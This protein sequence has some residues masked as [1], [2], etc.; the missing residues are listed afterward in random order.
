MHAL[1]LTC[2]FDTAKLSVQALLL[3]LKNCDTAHGS[4]SYMTL[5]KLARA[6]LLINR[7]SGLEP[8]KTYGHIL[9]LSLYIYLYV[10]T[11]IYRL[12]SLMGSHAMFP[13]SMFLEHVFLDDET[14]MVEF[15][16]GHTMHRFQRCL[17]SNRLGYPAALQSKFGC[18]A[19]ALSSVRLLKS[20][21]VSLHDMLPMEAKK[22]NIPLKES[23]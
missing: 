16:W 2:M 13:W 4:Y 7:R 9:S 22:Q 15:L 20:G 10:L 11:T 8:K 5:Q 18:L 19:T 17:F 6:S 1:L 23:F 14:C 21:W 3:T 12:W